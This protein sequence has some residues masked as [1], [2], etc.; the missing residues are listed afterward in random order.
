MAKQKKS[1]AK[2]KYET[3]A[4]TWKNRFETANDV[5]TPLFEKFAKYYDIKYATYNTDNMAPWRSKVYIPILSAKA[6]DMIA[7]L[8]GM[9]PGFDVLIRD[10]TPQSQEEQ[11]EIEA[12]REKAIEKL[13]YDY[14]NPLLEVP[15]RDKLQDALTDA[16]VVGVGITKTPWR[17]MSKE[18]RAHPIDEDGVYVDNDEEIVKKVE[19]G[20]NDVEPVNIFNFFID[21][22]A[23]SLQKAEWIIVREY[24]PLSVLKQRKKSGEAN[25]TNLDKLENNN[26]RNPDFDTF[27]QARN[28]LLNLQDENK[29][30]TVDRVEIYECYERASNK[31]C[32][33][34][35]TGTTKTKTNSWVKLLEKN[36][37]YWHGKYP[38]VAW[39]VKRKPF[40]FWGESLFETSERL[41]SA[42]NDIFNHYMDNWNL[43]IDGMIMQE[44]SSL[45][46]DYIVEPGGELVYSGDQP[47][48]FKFPEPNPTQ[49]SI[50]MDV[51]EKSIEQATISQ[52]S[53][54]IPDSSQDKT[55]GTAT[56]IIRLQEAANDKIGYFKA[57]F[58]K[59]LRELGQMWLFNNQQF[60]DQP[61]SVNTEKDG[62]KKELEVTPAD[63]QG[64]LE[65]QIIESEMEPV[66][67]EQ[68][69]ANHLEWVQHMLQLQQASVQQSQLTG[70]PTSILQLDIQAMADESARVFGIPGTSKF[71]KPPQPPQ[72]PQMPQMPIEGEV[73]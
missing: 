17:V 2:K 67:K 35:S 47:K 19:F 62:M 46:D 54:G 48:Q 29:D 15:T 27:N 9:K 1:Q 56:G 36:N 25:Y 61:I 38:M 3:T 4:T 14:D 44:E 51:L 73:L 18:Y 7:K 49:L 23:T 11:V 26:T 37:A 65:L 10:E 32:V 68:K 43:S 8:Y 20:Y 70:D 21:P 55:A 53:S 45:V 13:K 59:S 34:A 39:Y 60:L 6:D 12:R 52:F 41:Q 57:N 58:R 63:L 42:V 33:Y 24:I 66:S 28:R 64:V 30:D 40:Q 22:N 50:V 5:Q 72:M 31:I 16:A 69:K 71:V